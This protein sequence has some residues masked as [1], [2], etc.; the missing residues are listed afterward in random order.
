MHRL[1]ARSFPILLMQWPFYLTRWQGGNG[2]QFGAD[3]G[4]GYAGG[5]TTGVG[6]GV[7]LPICVRLLECWY[8]N[9]VCIAHQSDNLETGL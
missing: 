9:M 7:I 5:T 3:G 8:A 6:G 4:G 2:C 1:N